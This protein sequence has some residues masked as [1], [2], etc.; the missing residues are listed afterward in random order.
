MNYQTLNQLTKVLSD[1]CQDDT[2]RHTMVEALE[3][4]KHGNPKDGWKHS[5]N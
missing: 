2:C 5:I 3:S 4:A 1:Y